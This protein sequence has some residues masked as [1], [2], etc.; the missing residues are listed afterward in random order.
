MPP[1]SL[2]QLTVVCRKAIFNKKNHVYLKD[3]NSEDWNIINSWIRFYWFSF[4]ALCYSIF[5]EAFRMIL[6]RHFS[7]YTA[8]CNTVFVVRTLVCNRLICFVICTNSIVEKYVVH[9]SCG[10]TLFT[11][12]VFCSI[13]IL[14]DR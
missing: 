3:H 10:K 6:R 12:A 8:G 4:W 14:S 5:S 13:S 2:R 11:V 1:R 9:I 7:V